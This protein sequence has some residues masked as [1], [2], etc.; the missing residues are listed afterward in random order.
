LRW[1]TPPAFA[2]PARRPIHQAPEGWAGHPSGNWGRQE[3]WHRHHHAGY[4]P[5]LN[6]FLVPNLVGYP[7]GFGW[8]LDLGLDGDQDET[9]PQNPPVAA[10]Q[11]AIAEEANPLPPPPGPASDEFAQETESP[12]QY[13]P[14]Y[15]VSTLPEVQ[16]QPATTLIFNDG[17]PA[18]QVHNY[19]LTKT[20]LY[21][22]DG[23]MPRE[24][25]VSSIDLSATA[26]LNRSA[27][28]DFSPPQT[29]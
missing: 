7:V 3:G 20:T 5:V 19:I 23:G 25:P 1:N 22:L 12:T 18:K 6:G 27:G 10:P 21:N 28:V 16:P 2:S 9:E 29:P 26:K 13:R 14:D 8:T 4:S 15:R 17:Q 24:I 11:D